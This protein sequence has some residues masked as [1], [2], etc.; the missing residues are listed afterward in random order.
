MGDPGQRQ[1]FAQEYRKTAELY[2]QGQPD[3]E[4]LPARIHQHIAVM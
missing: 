3:F 1:R 2:Y 4:A